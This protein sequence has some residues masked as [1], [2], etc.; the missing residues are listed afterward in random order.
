VCCRATENV[1][2]LLNDVGWT[3]YNVCRSV[4]VCPE[5]GSGNTFGIRNI[6]L[7]TPPGRNAI[8]IEPLSA[9][10]DA[11]NLLAN[12]HQRADVCE[13]APGSDVSFQLTIRVDATRQ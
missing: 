9:P 12:R 8:S 1:A 2:I 13:V 3:A 4:E 10:P 7:F 11:L 5:A 6:Q